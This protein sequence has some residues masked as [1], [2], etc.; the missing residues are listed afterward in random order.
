MRS[1]SEIINL[2]DTYLEIQHTSANMT[3]NYDRGMYNG[4]EFIR[5]LVANTEPVYMLKDG[6]LDKEVM[7]RYPERYI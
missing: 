4:M 6:T 1:T 5:S 2:I 3:D 7:D